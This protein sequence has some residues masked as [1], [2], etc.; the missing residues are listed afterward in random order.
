MMGSML[1]GTQEAPGE[2][3]YADGVRLKKYRGMQR[4]VVFLSC[5]QRLHHAQVIHSFFT[6]TQYGFICVLFYAQ[7]LQ[8]VIASQL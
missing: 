6:I 4:R 3:F 1:A 8:G 5:L 2:Y 7:K